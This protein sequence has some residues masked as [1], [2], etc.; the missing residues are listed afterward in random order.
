MMARVDVTIFKFPYSARWPEMYEVCESRLAGVLGPK[1]LTLQALVTIAL[2]GC[3]GGG[4]TSVPLICGD[5]IMSTLLIVCSGHRAS[6]P[7]AG[8]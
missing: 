6:K 3:A 8:D 4:D 7:R 1:G 2:V 5:S